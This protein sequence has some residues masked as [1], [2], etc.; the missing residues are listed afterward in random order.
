MGYLL[1]R[2]GQSWILSNGISSREGGAIMDL[3]KW[4]TFLRERGSF[5]SYQEGC[6][7]EREGQLL[8]LSERVPI[9]EGENN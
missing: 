2:E 3:F 1:E 5:G 9:G 8:I 6:L 4:G 7:L